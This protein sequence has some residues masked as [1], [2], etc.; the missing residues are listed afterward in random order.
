MDCKYQ[1]INIRNFWNIEATKAIFIL[2]LFLLITIS[3][4]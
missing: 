2:F 1:I 3:L 4:N